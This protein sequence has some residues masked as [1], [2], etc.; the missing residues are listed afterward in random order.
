[1]KF[2]AD[3]LVKL[4]L[5]AI[6]EC[7]HPDAQGG[8][9]NGKGKLAGGMGEAAVFCHVI[10]IFKLPKVQHG[11][12]LSKASILLVLLIQ[13]NPLFFNEIK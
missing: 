1:M 6:F 2:A 3:N 5:E 7:L 12:S 9:L 10:E 13:Y 11:G 8:L 4:G